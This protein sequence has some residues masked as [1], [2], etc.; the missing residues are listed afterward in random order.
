MLNKEQIKK[1]FII[2]IVFTIILG[3]VDIWGIPF[4]NKDITQLYASQ[5]WFF[6]YLAIAIGAL[7]IWILK[8]DKSDAIAV[9]S[10]FYILSV[11]G[12][13]DFWFYILKDQSLP[14][15]MQHLFDNGTI[16]GKVAEFMGFSTVTP[17][18]LIVSM[19]LGLVVSYYLSQYLI[20]KF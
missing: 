11:S 8:K 15:T 9:G 16:M 12:W 3:A 19:I 18:S 14:S 13:E 17:T 5:F 6:A 10:I 2:V 7:M 4:W 20:K 1:V